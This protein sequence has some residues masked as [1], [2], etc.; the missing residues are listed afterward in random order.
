MDLGIS[1]RTAIVTGGSQ[2]I[3]K[4]VARCLASEGVRVAICARRLELLNETASEIHA[5]VGN[6]VLPVQADMSNTD[7]VK[8]LVAAALNA[9]GRIDILVNNA[10]S[11]RSAPLLELRDEDWLDH[12]NVKLLGYV[13]SVREVVPHM[14][15]NRWGRIINLAGGAARQVSH[16][17]YS[18]GAVNSAIANFTKRL[19][20]EVASFNITANTIH[21]GATRTGRREGAYARAM[22]EKGITLEEAKREIS[23]RV[24]I[25]RLIEPEDIACAVLFMASDCASAITGQVLAVDGGATRGIYY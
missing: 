9:F 25:G 12:F 3:G 22:M 4:A 19:A 1:G 20:D 24:P 5:Q 23:K 8:R 6:E 17:G 14:K 2:G 18:S 13:R 10:A 11:F 15:K 16:T 21:P 7:D